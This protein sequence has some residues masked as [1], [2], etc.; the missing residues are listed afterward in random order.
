[1]DQVPLFGDT[2]GERVEARVRLLERPD[3]HGRSRQART[4]AV[5]AVRRPIVGDVQQGGS[6]AW[7]WRV[8]AGVPGA[9]AGRSRKIG[10]SGG[11]ERGE[12]RGQQAR[13][14]VFVDICRYTHQK[15][16]GDGKISA[17]R[18]AHLD[19]RGTASRASVPRRKAILA[20]S[21]R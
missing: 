12:Q 20:K 11:V 14:W 13:I 21:S 10:E 17:G 18:L 5:D 8:A 4:P 3:A 7:E 6:P 2:A 1:M 15:A 19:D 16:L 9:V